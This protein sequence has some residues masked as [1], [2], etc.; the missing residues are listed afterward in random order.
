M[1]YTF[2]NNFSRDSNLNSYELW[3][4]EGLTNDLGTKSEPADFSINFAISRFLFHFQKRAPPL[5]AY[6]QFLRCIAEPYNV[7]SAHRIG[8]YDVEQKWSP[9]PDME[10]KKHNDG[11]RSLA[12]GWNNDIVCEMKY[13]K[14]QATDICLR[15]PKIYTFIS[16]SQEIFTNAQYSFTAPPRIVGTLQIVGIDGIFF[17]KHFRM[18]FIGKI[19]SAAC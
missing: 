6:E 1:E 12:L 3:Q 11:L 2:F 4:I 9:Q 14:Q 5:F 19:I 16:Y 13:C 15:H 18:A 17:N 7:Y 8:W 10:Q